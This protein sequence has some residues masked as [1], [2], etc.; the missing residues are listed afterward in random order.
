MDK[1]NHECLEHIFRYCGPKDWLILSE[2]CKSWRYIISKFWKQ[3]ERIEF[4]PT[5]Y[6]KNQPFLSTKKL[7]AILAQI[8]D[9]ITEIT[10]ISRKI[11]NIRLGKFV[12]NLHGLDL[13]V[14]WNA[15]DLYC[16]GRIKQATFYADIC[17]ANSIM[18]TNPGLKKVIL[19]MDAKCDSW[20]FFGGQV[21]ELELTRTRYCKV[22]C[23][24]V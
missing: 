16:T 2:V 8:G 1:L 20:S 13:A 22:P 10:I 4:V 11:G 23:D 12:Y 24:E 19:M 21:E 9:N 15:F 18:R 17:F 5:N 3:I 14:F 6:N 7:I